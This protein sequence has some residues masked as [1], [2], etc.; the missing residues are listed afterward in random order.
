MSRRRGDAEPSR[1]GELAEMAESIPRL[2]LRERCRVVPM[3]RSGHVVR[4]GLRPAEVARLALVLAVTLTAAHARAE[5][6]PCD[7]S[8]TVSPCFDADAL[9][10]PTGATHFATLPSPRP[11][12]EGA[13]TLLLGVGLALEP[14][15]L[16]AP[17]PDPDGRDIHVVKTTTTLTIG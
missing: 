7:A 13:A 5:P 2:I 1:R 11:L 10:L 9:W 17:S 12:A 4:W 8:A 15:M 14:V 16:S 3:R 6:D